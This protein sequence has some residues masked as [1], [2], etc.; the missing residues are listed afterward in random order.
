MAS[1]DNNSQP[2]WPDELIAVWS[3][4]K[5]SLWILLRKT[6]LKSLVSDFTPNKDFFD[7]QGYEKA[8]INN[9]YDQTINKLRKVNIPRNI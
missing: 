9:N 7:P 1:Q 2:L 4:K 3:K 6:L 8:L 5:K